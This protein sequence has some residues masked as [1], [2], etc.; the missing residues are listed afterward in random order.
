MPTLDSDQTHTHMMDRLTS[1]LL[2]DAGLAWLEPLRQ[3]AA[4]LDDLAARVVALEASRAPA[5]RPQRREPT[6]L[7]GRFCLWC[8]E[9]LRGQKR[10]YCN[11]AHRQRWAKEHPDEKAR[12][13]YQRRVRT[14]VAGV[15]ERT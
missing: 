1:T 14:F 4:A 3:I 5:E 8:D 13:I 15:G 10:L 12:P 7:N 11:S 9:P 6:A 2:A